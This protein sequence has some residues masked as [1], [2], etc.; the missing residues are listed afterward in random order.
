MKCRFRDCRYDTDVNTEASLPSTLSCIYWIYTCKQS[1]H[2]LPQPRQPSLPHIGGNQRSSLG[3]Q[4]GWMRPGRGGKT[5]ISIGL[6]RRRTRTSRG[7]ISADTWWHAVPRNSS[8][9]TWVVSSSIL[10]RPC[11]SSTW[12]SWPWSSRTQP[13]M[14]RSFWT[15]SRNQTG[16]QTFPLQVERGRSTLRLLRWD[17]FVRRKFPTRTA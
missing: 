4:W 2:S 17:A 12:S 10:S 11:C 1:M 16:D 7:Q 3:L 5:S 6:S 15:S 8:V 13:C 14:C 9:E